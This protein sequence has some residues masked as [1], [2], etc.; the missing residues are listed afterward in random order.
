[1]AEQHRVDPGDHRYDPAVLVRKPDV[2]PA[3]FFDVD[4]RVGRVTDVA[5]FPEAREPAWKL[6]VDFGP[7]I[8]VL[9]T[10]AKVTNYDADALHG[11]QVVGA[12]NLGH[13]RIAGFTSE[14]LLL[15][16]LEVDGRVRLLEVDG[17]LA[18]G[19]PVA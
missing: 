17:G 15:G 11:R 16:G 7:V 9:A 6:W 3:R 10:S 5:P 13:K 12:V 2:D 18:P 4:L 8:G 19:A 14:F 1:M